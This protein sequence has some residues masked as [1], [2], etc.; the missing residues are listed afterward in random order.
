MTDYIKKSDVIEKLRELVLHSS[1][2]EFYRNY[3]NV[4]NNLE[5]KTIDDGFNVGDE[6]YCI[7]TQEDMNGT[8]KS[9]IIKG[10]ILGKLYNIDFDDDDCFLDLLDE[11]D[12][13]KTKELAEQAL[14][15][16]D[17]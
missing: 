2:A 8:K 5:T 10:E 12:L 17:L 15:E 4:V 7:Q 6:C 1:H 16:G 3:T 9:E 13:Y 11:D 14:K